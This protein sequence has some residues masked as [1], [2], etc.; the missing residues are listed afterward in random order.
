MAKSE[1]STQ[2]GK[3]PKKKQSEG[4]RFCKFGTQITSEINKQ[5]CFSPN[6]FLQ[7]LIIITGESQEIIKI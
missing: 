1:N 7:F 6:F 4:V 5:I 2:G 3:S